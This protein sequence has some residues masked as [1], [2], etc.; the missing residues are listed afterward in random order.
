[1]SMSKLSGMI[2]VNG[3]LPP[4]TERFGDIS[5]RDLVRRI[6]TGHAALR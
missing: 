6:A 1:M 5:Q 4:A 3:A 2:T